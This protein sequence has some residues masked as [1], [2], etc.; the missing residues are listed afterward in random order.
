[1]K[2]M[3]AC[4]TIL[5]ALSTLPAM[6]ATTTVS[7]VITD[8]MCGNKHMSSGKPDSD[9]VRACVKEGAHFAVEADG[10]IYVLAGKN[11]EV[12]AFAGKK[13]TVSGDLKGNTLTVSSIAA[14]K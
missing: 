12:S 6:A 1:M 13:V 4:A 10:K 8:D 7:G 11:T 14:A 9:C 3:F 5:A 2:K